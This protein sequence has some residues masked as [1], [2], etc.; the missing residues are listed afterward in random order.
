MLLAIDTA[1]S[2]LGLALYDGAQVL[3]E[4]VWYSGAHHTTELAPEVALALRRAGLRQEDLTTI[5]VA[6]GPG[7]Y[8]GLR[9]GLALAKGL[10]L[11]HNLQ[12]V[13]IPTL[14]VLA[15]AQPEAEMPMVGLLQAGR[16]RVAA[17]W[18]KWGRKGWSARKGAKT[19]SWDQF[20]SELKETTYVCGELDLEGREVLK[21][22]NF[23][24]LAP[25]SL[26]VRRPGVL[27]ELAWEKARRGKTQDPAELSPIYL[28]PIKQ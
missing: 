2:M 26:N 4:S 17:V 5:G 23:A 21:S 13:G 25:P 16:G 24:V 8:T 27:A 20:G 22:V 14:D 12:I 9:I 19:L 15:A 6:L 7:S 10:S 3:N 11:A 18:Y 1:T 28:D